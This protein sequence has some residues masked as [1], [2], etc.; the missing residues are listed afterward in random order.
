M[1]LDEFA[2]IRRHFA[3]LATTPAALGLG[4]DAA[5]LAVEAGFEL[6]VTTDTLV[7]GVHFLD[8]DP[9]ETLGHKLLAVN[10]SDLAAM[11]A[12]PVA[13][14]LSVAVPRG[15]SAD[16]GDAWLA[17]FA[18]GL[19]ALQRAA[20]IT[21]IGGDT[22][23]APHDLALGLTAIGR[24]PAGHALRRSG[25]R[26][27]DVVWVSGA[28]GDGALDLAVLRGEL[29]E[30]P[31]SAAAALVE[32]YRRPSPRLALGRRLVGLATAAADVSDGLIADLDHICEAS[33]VSAELV[34]DRL[35]LSEA[36][37]AVVGAAR[38]RLVDLA[39]GGDDYELVFTAPPTAADAVIEAAAAAS[40]GVAEVGRIGAAPVVPAAPTKTSR[41]KVVLD[42][43]VV[44]VPRG[45]YSHFGAAGATKRAKE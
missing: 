16:A 18:R 19:E 31:P 17:A 9:A 45:G 43:R 40:V 2:L 38:S 25:A 27:G 15:W 34:L 42:G 4:D 7:A 3:P 12:E 22:V 21:L 1:A 20:G 5:V 28:I 41:V 30:V 11:G 14:L 23:A 10:L 29:P 32:R 8:G 39:A 24:V 44:S 36:A 13:Y 26:P 37:A 35:P 33:G 6:V